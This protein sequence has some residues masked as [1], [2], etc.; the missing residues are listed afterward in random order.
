MI[1]LILSMVLFDI[2]LVLLIIHM[3]EMFKIIIPI[4]VIIASIC[5]NIDGVNIVNTSTMLLSCG[6]FQLCDFI[7]N[8]YKK[9]RKDKKL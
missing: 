8:A 6:I 2:L 7:Y 9:Y 4:L 5:L 1:D 3:P